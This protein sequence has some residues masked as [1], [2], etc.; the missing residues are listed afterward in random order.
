MT[1]AE[2]M[3]TMSTSNIC[4]FSRRIVFSYRLEVSCYV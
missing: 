1:A 2:H 4:I 3:Y